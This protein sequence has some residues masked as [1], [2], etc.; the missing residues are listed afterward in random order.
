MVDISLLIDKKIDETFVIRAPKS[1]TSKSVQRKAPVSL[2]PQTTRQ[3]TTLTPK[4][5]I[6]EEKS[7]L[8]KAA[9]TRGESQENYRSDV[10]TS[11]VTTGKNVGD[12]YKAHKRLALLQHPLWIECIK[13]WW[14]VM[15][16]H[17]M[18]EP[19]NTTDGKLSSEQYLDLN[20]RLQKALNPDFDYENACVSA[21]EDW[22]VDADDWDGTVSIGETQHPCTPT[23]NYTRSV[24]MPM[25]KSFTFDKFSEFLF[26]TGEV[27][28]D[29]SIESIL[30][31]VNSVMLHIS[32][33]VHLSSSVFK[34]INEISCMPDL[35]FQ[36]I[37]DMAINS[38]TPQHLDFIKW[39]QINFLEL[40]N[41]RIYVTGRL[42]SILPSDSRVS[43]LWLSQDGYNQTDVLIQCT[44]RLE[45]LLNRISKGNPVALPIKD[46]SSKPKIKPNI[47]INAR[48]NP[49]KSLVPTLPYLKPQET[50]PVVMKNKITFSRNI[51]LALVGQ[52]YASR[53][54]NQE[55]TEVKNSN[56]LSVLYNESKDIT[57]PNIHV[58]KPAVSQKIGTDLSPIISNQSSSSSLFKNKDI[59]KR[60]YS[61]PLNNDGKIE[62]FKSRSHLSL[63]HT[64][65]KKLFEESLDPEYTPKLQFGKT[66]VKFHKLQK[67][68]RKG[69]FQ[70]TNPP[71]ISPEIGEVN[72]KSPV[73]YA[74]LKKNHGKEIIRAYESTKKSKFQEYSNEISSPSRLDYTYKKDTIDEIERLVGIK[75]NTEPQKSATSGISPLK[76]SEN[77][78]KTAPNTSARKPIEKKNLATYTFEDFSHLI[79]AKK[80]QKLVFTNNLEFLY[81][82]NRAKHDF[83][84]THQSEFLRHYSK[85]NSEYR[86]RRDELGGHISPSDWKRFIDHLENIIKVTKRRR[87]NRKI[88]RKKRGKSYGVHK[89][90]NLSK[91][92]LWKNVFIKSINQEK[93]SHE[94]YSKEIAKINEKADALPYQLQDLEKP[95]PKFPKPPTN[96]KTQ[97]K[98]TRNYSP[99]RYRILTA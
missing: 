67:S 75:I 43:D 4:L 7:L 64:D 88:R 26:E 29:G 71:L 1:Y 78:A 93:I 46:Q 81:A 33:G 23:S 40:E 21:V 77:P 66:D 57:I 17:D 19:D 80:Q 70:R 92:R 58:I 61:T 79:K 74:E 15:D 31:L 76:K 16:P 59:P 18:V 37:S 82:L 11:V 89:G 84:T 62:F 73:E 44:N 60:P 12:P 35:L 20:V 97:S 28:T 52:P 22:E 51:K 14:N 8:V 94:R 6:K 63:P 5:N 90:P 68:W 47:G 53:L 3:K 34:D 98:S 91:N 72:K 39:Y 69:K 13:A 54:Q 83:N 10:S 27:W 25:Q 56:Q 2:P 96:P 95:L 86:S 41:M 99:R 30:V 24:T 36:E 50:D 42:F 85:K 32:H 45:G 49:K 87:K 65:E 9:K 38:I 55:L 48:T